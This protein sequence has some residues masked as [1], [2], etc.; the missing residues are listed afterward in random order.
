MILIQEAD[1]KVHQQDIESQVTDVKTVLQSEIKWVVQWCR[2]RR[3]QSI[4]KKSKISNMHDTIILQSH[5]MML[6]DDDT[7]SHCSNEYDFFFSCV[8]DNAANNITIEA[9]DIC[10]NCLWSGHRDWCF[11]CKT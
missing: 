11:L 8:V 4:V 3:N 5:N 2:D 6:S 10:I 9:T 7:C 1:K